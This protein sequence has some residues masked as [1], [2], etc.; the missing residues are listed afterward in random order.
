MALEEAPKYTTNECEACHSW[1]WFGA[2]VLSWSLKIGSMVITYLP[3]VCGDNLPLM[4]SAQIFELDDLSICSR[5]LLISY[6]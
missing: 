6:H 5:L 1:R 4:I 3:R 2:Q